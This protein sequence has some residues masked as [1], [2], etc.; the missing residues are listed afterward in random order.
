MPVAAFLD[1]LGYPFYYPDV[2][3]YIK[4]HDFKFIIPKQFEAKIAKDADLLDGIGPE[5]VVRTYHVG[6]GF[7]NRY[8]NPDLTLDQRFEYLRTGTKSPD[9]VSVIL[10]LCFDWPKMLNTQAAKNIVKKDEKGEKMIKELIRFSREEEKLTLDEI[11]ILKRTVREYERESP[12]QVELQKQRAAQLSEQELMH[13]I[14]Y[15]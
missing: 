2:M 4:V 13:A 10:S 1:M 8:F 12:R 15:E 7:G 6:R 3:N 11:D 14:W 5:A 9:T